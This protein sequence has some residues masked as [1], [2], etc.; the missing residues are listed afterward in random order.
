[1]TAASNLTRDTV[2]QL[3]DLCE[4][5]A[6]NV[7][8]AVQQKAEAYRIRA[9]ILGVLDGFSAR[10]E[11]VKAEASKAAGAVSANPIKQEDLL[12]SLLSRS[13][14]G[15]RI[16]ASGTQHAFLGA[17]GGKGNLVASLAAAGY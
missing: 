3:L 14:A 11:A 13:S 15:L 6:A 1:M 12:T 9:E 2:G 8:K 16:T 7:D 10:L 5:A 4:T 17:P